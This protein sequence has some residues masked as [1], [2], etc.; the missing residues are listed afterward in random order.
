[1]EVENKN[2]AL[3]KLITSIVLVSFFCFEIL[4][5]FSPL[6]KV[7]ASEEEILINKIDIITN[8]EIIEESNE[9]HDEKDEYTTLH[10]FIDL[11]ASE[12][13]S[14]LY[15]LQ[16]KDREIAFI[17]SRTLPSPDQ[18][19]A[20]I[21]EKCLAYGCNAS[22]LIRVMYCESKANPRASNGINMG[23]FQQDYRFW[24]ARAATYGL[25]GA[26]IFDPYA[27]IHVAAQMFAQG[28]ASHW[29]CK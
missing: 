1:M 4:K 6:D 14:K 9:F 15:E 3:F 17:K 27:Q 7:L 28:M 21:R 24:A 18:Y 20:K 16:R 2:L 19:E 13:H 29:T 23:L 10:K 8:Q 26:D 22:Q 12:L 11:L 25:P 5:I